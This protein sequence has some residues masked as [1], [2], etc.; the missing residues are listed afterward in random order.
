MGMARAS[1][2]EQRLRALTNPSLSRAVLSSRWR[3]ALAVSLACV[4][5]GVSGLRAQQ[6]EPVYKQG[7]AG[8]VGPK[9]THRVDAKYSPD[10]EAQGI[11]GD[12]TLSFEVDKDGKSR[13]IKIVEGLD[14]EL[15]KNAVEALSAWRFDPA[16]KDGK[17]VVFAAK[18]K[19]SFQLK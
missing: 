4:V 8:V 3:F 13:N 19:V 17:P 9:V 14:P 11:M 15:D 6:S 7:D 2:L 18:V 10:A 12:V 16:T 1:S 5:L